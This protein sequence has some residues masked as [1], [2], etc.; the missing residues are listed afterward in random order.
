MRC[1]P[2]SC[3]TQEKIA[4]RC[5][6][7]LGAKRAI[8]PAEYNSNLLSESPVVYLDRIY[9]K[10]G[11]A[12]ET[13]LGNGQR[14]LKTDPRIAAFGAVDELNSSLGV[15]IALGQL[16]G[17]VQSQ[18][19][20]MQNDLFDLGADLCVPESDAPREHEPLR[21]QA[22]QVTQLEHWIDAA[23]D[24][25]TPLRSFILPG[26]SAGAAL[27]HQSRA[28]CRRAEIAVYQLASQAAINPQ[29]TTYLNR[30][31]DLLFVMARVANAGGQDDILWVPGGPRERP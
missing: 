26:G 7:A 12:G 13:S 3:A 11:D 30:L 31:S 28:I 15:A 27:L 8:L 23:T 6:V 17:D 1:L 18:L 9:T 29:A 14:V 4:T 2:A 19:R 21:T 25:L 24:Q 16:P 10:S 5:S 22:A 20:Q